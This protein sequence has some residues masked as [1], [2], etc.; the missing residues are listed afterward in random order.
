MD[1]L[2]SI[3][4]LRAV[5][6]LSVARAHIDRDARDLAAQGG[7]NYVNAWPL[8]LDAGVDLF[9]VISGFVMVYASQNLFGKPR[10]P[11]IFF[12]RRLA[13]I[14]PVYWACTVAFVGVAFVLPGLVNGPRPE[15]LG[16]LRSLFFVPYV[17][18]LGAI[19]PVLT[20]GW[21]LNYEMFFYAIFAGFVFLP[22][23]AA[24]LGIMLFLL[25][26]AGL[27]AVLKP[28]SAPL[29]FWTNPIVLEFVFGMIVATARIEG[30]RLGKPARAGLVAA[31]VVLLTALGANTGLDRWIIWGA[32]AGLIVAGFALGEASGAA[33][34]AWRF[35]ARLGDAS[36]AM[37][38]IHPFL[39]RPMR[40]LWQALGL[41]ST[42]SVTVFG[43]ACFAAIIFVALAVYRK[44]ERPLTRALQAKLPAA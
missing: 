33:G 7:W 32:P 14:V 22:R 17:N 23:R 16:V 11:L 26:A 12:A 42:F 31:G 36:Y 44:F 34:P 18:E 1:R 30:L 5:A 21:T 15:L 2:A 41:T 39:I 10:A 8:P 3:Q 37:Y 25:I 24:T 38:L 29:Q 6:A 27:G 20:L 19:Q 4:F 35:A 40:A 28:A 13:R 43:L 9:F